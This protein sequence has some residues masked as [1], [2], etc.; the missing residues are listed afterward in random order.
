MKNI[1]KSLAVAGL[2]VVGGTSVSF[3]SS[4]TSADTAFEKAAE[5]E[6]EHHI[7][8][9]YK[10]PTKNAKPYVCDGT[11]EDASARAIQMHKDKR[12]ASA[13]MLL[14]PPPSVSPLAIRRRSVSLTFISILPLMR[15]LL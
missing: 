10:R 11:C 1:M 13:P 15:T 2:I 12:M 5:L 6:V 8:G 4:G 7:N 9:K 3:A 14:K